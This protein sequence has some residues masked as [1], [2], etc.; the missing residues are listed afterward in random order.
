M[1]ETSGVEPAGAEE[2]IDEPDERT[3]SV[4]DSSGSQ[5]SKPDVAECETL[6]SSVLRALLSI[7]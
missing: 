1:N 4:D 6:D 2:L 7:C 3:A 5:L